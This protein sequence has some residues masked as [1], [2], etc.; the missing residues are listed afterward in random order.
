MINDIFID[1][2][3]FIYARGKEHSYKKSCAEVIL[4]IAS[5]EFQKKWG[6]PVIDTEVL[7]E[8]LYRYFYIKDLKTGINVCKDIILLEIETLKVDLKDVNKSLELAEEYNNIPPR[9]LIHC[10]VM[11]NNKIKK[12]ITVDK[13]FKKIKEIETTN[14]KDIFKY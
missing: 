11:L 14:P 2:N 1:T 4:K 13:H 9:D 6:N 10:A 7:Q 5:G 3:V 12:I 8:L